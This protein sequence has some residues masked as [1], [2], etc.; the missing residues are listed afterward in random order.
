MCHGRDTRRSGQCGYQAVLPSG[1]K[2]EDVSADLA[3]GVLTITA[4]EAR[5]ATARGGERPP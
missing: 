2:T 3:A 1:V 4:P 5:A